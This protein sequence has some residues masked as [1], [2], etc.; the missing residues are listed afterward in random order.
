MREAMPCDRRMTKRKRAPL[1][2]HFVTPSPKGEGK[3][4]AVFGTALRPIQDPS[5]NAR[6]DKDNFVFRDPS[7]RF[8]R[9]G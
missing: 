2:R 7:T 6:D 5:T 9:S 1:F 8:A 4:R 3:D